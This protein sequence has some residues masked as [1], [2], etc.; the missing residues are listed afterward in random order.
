MLC[1]VV[2]ELEEV[3]SIAF[4]LL[5]IPVRFEGL[6]FVFSPWYLGSSYSWA[7]WKQLDEK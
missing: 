4:D 3:C 1:A 2:T 6:S 5:S 7:S